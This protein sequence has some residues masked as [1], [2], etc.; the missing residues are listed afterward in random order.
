MRRLLSAPPSSAPGDYR[1]PSPTAPP[2]AT[3]RGWSPR[4]ASAGHTS[5][6]VPAVPFCRRAWHALPQGVLST[7]AVPDGQSR[8]TARTTAPGRHST[9]PEGK[10]SPTPAAAR[11][12]T[13]TVRFPYGLPRPFPAGM[14]RTDRASRSGAAGYAAGCFAAPATAVFSARQDGGAAAWIPRRYSAA[15]ATSC[16]SSRRATPEP[17]RKAAPAATAAPALSK[18]KQAVC[19]GCAAP[20]PPQAVPAARANCPAATIPSKPVQAGG[21]R[22][23]FVRKIAGSD[24]S[25]WHSPPI[26]S[27]P[28]FPCAA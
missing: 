9:T 14:R 20:A 15:T 18:G 11:R 23:A 1:T 21:G 27:A 26:S 22:G 17:A 6:A 5:P 25:A 4:A 10:V 2:E 16:T 7:P 8:R 13:D 12:R 24:V 3:P 19:S 28:I